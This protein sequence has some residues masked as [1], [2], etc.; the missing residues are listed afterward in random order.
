MHLC[1]QVDQLASWKRI[2]EMIDSVPALFELDSFLNPEVYLLIVKRDSPLALFFEMMAIGQMFVID[3]GRCS[4]VSVSLNVVVGSLQ[5]FHPLA[6][7]S[8]SNPLDAE[9]L[10]NTDR[11]LQTYLRDFESW[12]CVNMRYYQ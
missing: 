4:V 7:S 5:P 9:V 2:V 3:R 1:L 11:H 8:S 12:T 10:S 6:A